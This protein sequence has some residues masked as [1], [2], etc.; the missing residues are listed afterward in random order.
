MQ[1]VDRCSPE[2]AKRDA[3]SAKGSRL[4]EL[5]GK[6]FFKFPARPRHIRKSA[7]LAAFTVPVKVG[8]G[9]LATEW[10][11]TQPAARQETLTGIF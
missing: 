10:E 11:R 7:A 9:V 8:E 2:L 1:P 5:I 4:G 3:Q 6:L